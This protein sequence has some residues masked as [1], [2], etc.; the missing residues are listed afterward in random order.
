MVDLAKENGMTVTSAVVS[1]D[2]NRGVMTVEQAALR[3]GVSPRTMR[4]V[5]AE[6]RI[7]HVRIGR[8]VRLDESDVDGFLARCTVEAVD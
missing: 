3:I 8:L 1:K 5:V 7:R 4:R 6:R 2:T